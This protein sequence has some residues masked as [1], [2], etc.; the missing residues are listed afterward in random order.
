MPEATNL[1]TP[2]TGP[3]ARL[4]VIVYVCTTMWGSPDTAQ[5]ECEH[6]A[7]QSRW[8]VVALLHD[9]CGQTDPNNPQHRPGLARALELIRRGAA[10]VLLAP[11]EQA[12]SLLGKERQEFARR[13]ANAGGTLR[14]ATEGEQ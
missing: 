5:A 8:E 14:T 7:H 10:D 12:I 6:F 9:R 3:A 11:D 1:P 4:R 13:V 2:L